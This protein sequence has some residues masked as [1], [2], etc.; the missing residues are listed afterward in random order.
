MDG[1]TDFIHGRAEGLIFFPNIHTG[2]ERSSTSPPEDDD[3]DGSV[4]PD[5]KNGSMEYTPQFEGHGVVLL[6]PVQGKD[7]VASVALGQHYRRGLIHA[8]PPFFLMR[9][10]QAITFP[11]GL[12]WLE[13][14]TVPVAATGLP[15]IR[16]ETL[17]I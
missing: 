3:T 4:L 13:R 17:P 5:L 2:T 8:G 10:R 11:C 16:V 12:M 6:G 14:K 15:G 9:A 7:N 1:A